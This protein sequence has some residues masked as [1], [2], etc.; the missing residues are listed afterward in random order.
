MSWGLEAE[1]TIAEV[2]DG[3]IDID[4]VPEVGLG[5]GDISPLEDDTNE[6]EKELTTID[7]TTGSD[8]GAD[9]GSEELRPIEP[10]DERGAIELGKGDADG[11]IEDSELEIARLLRVDIE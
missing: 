10:I 6:E 9:A 3:M 8:P 11:V 4:M 7:D 5:G 1:A 2:S